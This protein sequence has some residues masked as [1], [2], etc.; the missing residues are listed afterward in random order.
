MKYSTGYLTASR[1]AD[2]IRESAAVG[3]K[4]KPAG[5]LAGREERREEDEVFLEDIRARYINSVRNMF[6]GISDSINSQGQEVSYTTEEEPL[7]EVL[8]VG[9]SARFPGAYQ[10]EAAD[11]I[12]QKLMDRGMSEEI[13][14]GFVMN[15]MDESGLNPLINEINPVVEGSRG[16]F[17]LYQLTGDRRVN[18]E[19]YI[20]QLGID[21]SDPMAQED[22][23]I[24]FLFQELQG[25][26]NRAWERIQSASDAGTAAAL[27]ARDFLRPAKEHLNA[28]VAKYT[29][30]TPD[31][32]TKPQTY[33]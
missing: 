27:I 6:G 9:Q 12:K 15:F 22:A 25:S 31:Y 17:G 10:S 1:M 16:G 32:I 33:Y 23:Q 20:S 11:R 2:M 8:I 3:K 14:T 19:N 26:E 13:A 18:Y 30:R 24:D 28:R 7:D 29:G 4:A 5:G 21:P